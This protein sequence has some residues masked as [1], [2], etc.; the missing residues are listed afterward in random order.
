M[1]HYVQRPR[2]T[3]NQAATDA[4]TTA[5]FPRLLAEALVRRG[6]CSAEDAR[7][8]LNPAQSEPENPFLLPDMEKAV[9]R[10]LLA[11]GSGERICVYG[12][13]DAD[14]ICATA[15]LL[16]ALRE[17]GANVCYRL[18]SRHGEGYG[19]NVGAIE[20]LASDGVKL[21]LT[22][23]NGISAL[24]EIACARRLGVD[25]VVTDHHEPGEQLP[26]CMAVVAASRRDSQY[27]NRALCGAGTAYQLARALWPD[28][29]HS[30]RLALAAVATIADVVPL[31]GENRTIVVQGLPILP[32][33]PAVAALLHAS[34]MDGRPLSETTVAF[35]IAPRLNAAGRM[36]E[37]ERA[38]ELFLSEN[39]ALTASLAVTLE[40]ENRKRRAEETRIQAEAEDMLRLTARGKRAILLYRENWNPGVIGI[41]AARMV[42][43]YGRPTIL[44]SDAGGVLTGSGRS[45]DGVNLYM[46]L[47]ACSS[48]FLRFGG[49]AGAAGITMRRDAFDAF[50]E[51]FCAI[52][53]TLPQTL[54][55]PSCAYEADVPLSALDRRTVETLLEL[56]PFGE[57]NPEPVFRVKNVS[58]SDVRLMGKESQHLSATVS[59]GTA[60]LRMTAFGFGAALSFLSDPNTRWDLVY[61]PV[62]NK[63]NNKV[64]IELRARAFS[65]S[66]SVE[67]K[68]IDAFLQK[69]LYN[70]MRS[71]SGCMDA[72]FLRAANP[73]LTE[74]DMRTHYRF[75][76]AVWEK[77]EPDGRQ[78]I[79]W[80][81][82]SQ[83]LALSVFGELGFFLADDDTGAMHFCPQAARRALADSTLFRQISE[84]RTLKG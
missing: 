59:D 45:L 6:I 28:S 26:E 75:L 44:F 81:S 58:F 31:R 24:D 22:V 60:S 82:L 49:H 3:A 66:E 55:L 12:D 70:D 11:V 67:Q 63:F 83:Y 79:Q 46:C 61:T 53:D 35:G 47:S 23:D 27:P 37:A 73:S 64:S 20:A 34:G 30:V 15:I 17:N 57:G 52:L 38:L 33:L 65:P 54:F 77:A 21:I 1:I 50:S 80:L 32:K 62:I 69:V 29:D 39:A 41:V 43:R 51:Q 76:R 68:I 56:Q 78:A 10:I 18:P 8:F 40:E 42:E 2:E 16:T 84:A 72:A 48:H 4:L 9:T 7:A 5:G 14:G 36:G 13:Y 71:L 25:V 74:N 19:L